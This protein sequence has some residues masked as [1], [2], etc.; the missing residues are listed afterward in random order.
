MNQVIIV[1]SY[2]MVVTIQSGA[3]GDLMK[4]AAQPVG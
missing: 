4:K 1:T 3:A 2:V